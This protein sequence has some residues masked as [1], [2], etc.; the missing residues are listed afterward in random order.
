MRVE[1]DTPGSE[2]RVPV[3]MA[4]RTRVPPV[5]RLSSPIW[6][7]CDLRIVKGSTLE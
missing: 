5:E 2:M 6:I 3:V 4:P 7:W 1:K